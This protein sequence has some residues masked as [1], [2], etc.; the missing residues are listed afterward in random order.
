MV[1]Q[2]RG[3]KSVNS[4]LFMHVVFIAI[5]SIVLSVAAQFSLKA[6]MSSLAVNLALA[7]PLSVKTA[8]DVLTNRYVFIGFALYGIGAIV[9]LGVLSRWDVS[10]AYPM[11]GLGFVLTAAVGAVM[12]ENITLIRLLG[13]GLICAGVL[14]VA[15]S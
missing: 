14:L 1:C 12:G 10:K 13:I 6:G 2:E 15:R 11:V 4:V 5:A 9:W 3:S 8:F 7:E